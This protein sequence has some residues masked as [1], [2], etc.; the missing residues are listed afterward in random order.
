MRNQPIGILDSGVGGLTV[1]KEIVH[2]LPHESIMYIGDSQ[3]TPYGQYSAD[4]IHK[5]AKKLVDF[6]ISKKA[7][8]IVIACNTITV[9]CL[10]KL[11]EEYPQIP[12]IGTVPVVKTAA[13]VTKNKKIGILST[14]NTAKST[15]QKHLVEK[16]ANNCYVFEHGTDELV[17]LIEKGEFNGKKMNEVLERTLMK[18]KREEIDTLALACTHFPFVADK[19][20]EILGDKVRLLDSGAAIARQVQRVLDNNEAFANHTTP[21]YAFFTTGKKESFEKVAKH[22]GKD[23][24]TKN[25]HNISL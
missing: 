7:K 11:R 2:L 22:L 25:I 18:F 14:T 9:S 13:E 20:H 23:T 1:F 5:L 16:F 24:I 21:T 17:P 10:D 3:S 6:L 19:M 12:I 8:I 4:K 15:Y